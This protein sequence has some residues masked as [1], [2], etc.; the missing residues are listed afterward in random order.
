MKPTDNTPEGIEKFYQHL[1]NN[2][3]GKGLQLINK[4]GIY[5][6]LTIGNDYKAID[7]IMYN[8][9]MEGIFVMIRDDN[10]YL[11]EI[12]ILK[13]KV[14]ADEVEASVKKKTVFEKFKAMFN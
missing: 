3:T 9:T 14:F 6:P 7:F 12:P 4:D 5:R 10:E 11:L 13:F 2:V 1:Q 8:H